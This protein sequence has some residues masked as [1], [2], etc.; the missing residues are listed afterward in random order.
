MEVSDAFSGKDRLWVTLYFLMISMRSFMMAWWASPNGAMSKFVILRAWLWRIGMH[1]YFST[2][3]ASL[4]V[5]IVAHLPN[6]NLW[7]PFKSGWHN[8]VLRVLSSMGVVWYLVP[9][10]I[11]PSLSPVWVIYQYSLKLITRSDFVSYRRL[12]QCIIHQDFVQVNMVF[13][14]SV[15]VY[16][17]CVVW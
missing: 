8:S 11:F 13:L 1:Q 14:K 12:C 7:L 5:I 10:L 4:W 15:I 9:L 17:V 3:L 6:A 2:S 16:D